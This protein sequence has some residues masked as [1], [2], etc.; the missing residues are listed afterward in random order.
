MNFDLAPIMALDW[1]SIGA[2]VWFASAALVGAISGWMLLR[3][4]PWPSRLMGT[5]GLAS[6]MGTA[7]LLIRPPP[8]DAELDLPLPTRV[9]D[10]G[11]ASSDTC[12]ACHPG[13]YASWHDSFHRTMTQVATGQAVRAPF[14][15][16]V[17]SE[18]G[19]NFQ[20]VRREDAFYVGEVS[21]PGPHVVDEAFWVRARRVVMTTGSHHMQA[22]WVEGTDGK[23]EQV[24]FVYFIGEDRWLA[25]SD[26]FLEPPHAAD[27]ALVRYTW[28]DSCVTCHSTGGPWSPLAEQA[29]D[30]TP[31]VRITE[32]GISCEACHGPGEE[33]VAA[34][35]SP[36]RRYARHRDE[37]EGDPTIVNPA[38]LSNSRS[39]SVCGRCH[40]VHPD[41]QGERVHDFHPGDE[42][43]QYLAID[44]MLRVVDAARDVDDLGWLPPDEVDTVGSFWRDGNVRVAGREHTG[45][46]RSGCYL[47]GEMNCTTCHSMHE[48][49]PN[50]QLASADHSD[51]EMCTTCHAEIAL[52]VGGHTHHEAES[53]GSRCV[54][55]H[56]PYSS[57]ALLMATRSHDMQGPRASGY[58]ARERPNACNLCHLDQSIGWTAVHLERWYGA[59]MATVAQREDDVPAGV[60]WMVRGDAV[61]RAIAAWHVGWG[62]ARSSMDPEPLR[63][64]LEALLTDR[65]SAV[66]QIAAR[67]LQTTYEGVEVD[68][69]ALTRDPLTTSTPDPALE[70]LLAERDTRDVAIPE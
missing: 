7:T 8:A 70:P 68:F 56:M 57:Y 62:P 6:A 14:D 2:V 46:I 34:N 32:L 51:D 50:R 27:G 41:G 61:H 4:S 18:R 1:R 54:N 15:G 58:H 39:A 25:N 12:R 60:H 26:S 40:S 30:P 36:A 3:G 21:S 31:E 28:S 17:L 33:H 23:L 64:A 48:S 11:Y 63:P 47:S 10:G 53:V 43:D 37:D 42:L 49:E 9:R 65:Y 16:R 66:R 19:R 69:D 59:R 24:P 45:M 20:F 13:Q 44:A 35:R 67:S 5:L 22:F 55:C 52:D 29:S 38:T